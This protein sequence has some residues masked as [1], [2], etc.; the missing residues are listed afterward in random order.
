MNIFILNDGCVRED[1]LTQNLKTRLENENHT[2]TT[3]YENAD[4]LIYT[5]CAITSYSIDEGVKTSYCLSNLKRKT[6][7]L[8]IT[9]CIAGL[10][11]KLDF[12]QKKEDIKI[13]ENKDL[14]VP[15]SNYINEENKRITK[16]LPLEHATRNNSRRTIK[17]DRKK[18]RKYNKFQYKY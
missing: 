9:E 13:I 8:I 15:V 7:P 4:I 6:S 1:A 12:A 3:D 10:I 11:K 5:T 17:K 2:I 14:I 16:K 18:N